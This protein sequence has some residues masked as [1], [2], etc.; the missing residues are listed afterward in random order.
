MER[1]RS[2][3]NRAV[4]AVSVSWAGLCAGSGVVRLWL[5]DPTLDALR[6]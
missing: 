3:L 6:L 1:A 5:M 4:V 2:D